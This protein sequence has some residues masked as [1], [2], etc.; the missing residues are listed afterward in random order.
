MKELCNSLVIIPI[1]SI[2]SSTNG[3]IN[4]KPEGS[5]YPIHT[6]EFTITPNRQD[7]ESGTIY[8]IDQ[9]ITIDKVSDK[10]ANYFRFT[11]SVILELKLISPDPLK[12]KI[13]I[14]SVEL[15]AKVVIT[16]HLQKDSLNI[17][18]KSYQSPL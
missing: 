6:D 15:P 8:E 12:P 10:Y 18:S 11:R 5:I 9:D 1:D 14:G 3:T 4:L 13:Y 16:T 7:S 17:K 2:Q